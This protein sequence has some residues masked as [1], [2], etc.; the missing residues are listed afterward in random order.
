MAA[1]LARLVTQGGTKRCRLFGSVAD[2]GMN[3]PDPNFKNAKLL[4]YIAT[5]G[6]AY[7]T[8]S[9]STILIWP[10]ASSK[11]EDVSYYH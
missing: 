4:T 5:C 9:L 1:A 2:P 7:P 11:N 10:N 6:K 3:I 8:I